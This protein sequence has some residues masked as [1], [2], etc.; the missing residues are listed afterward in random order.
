MLTA[1][2]PTRSRSVLILTRCHDRAQVGRH[3]LIQ[4]QQREAAVVD[5]DVQRVERLVAR[6][7]TRSIRLVVAIDEALHGQA[8]VFLGEPAHFEQPRS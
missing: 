1:R 2:S 4:R 8:H 5:L 7:A 3:R 6:R